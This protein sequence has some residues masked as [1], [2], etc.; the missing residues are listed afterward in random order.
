MRNEEDKKQKIKN[1]NIWEQEALHKLKPYAKQIYQD[2]LSQKENVQD[3]QRTKSDSV[4][5]EDTEYHRHLCLR[6]D[7][8]S[9][10][11]K[12]GSPKP[13][14]LWRSFQSQKLDF[15]SQLDKDKELKFPLSFHQ[16]F[17]E[18][19]SYPENHQKN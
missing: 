18:K 19:I 6:S 7:N 8:H 14:L 3:Q 11:R 1:N 2:I 13:P 9:P 16:G 4:R 17:W 12:V 10:D 15:P 5:K